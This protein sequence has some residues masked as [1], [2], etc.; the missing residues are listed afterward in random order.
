MTEQTHTHDDIIVFDV[1]TQHTFDEVGGIENRDKLGISYVGL[2]SYSQKK[3]FG[4]FEK[5]LPMLEKILLKT[6]PMLIG[7]NSIHFDVPVLQPYFTQ[8]NLSELPHLDMLKE[9][10]KVLGHRLKL[11]SIAQGTIFSQKSGDGLDAIR[12]YREG[13]FDALAKYCIDDVAITRDIYEFGEKQ[14]AI[15]YPAAGMRKAVKISWGKPPLIS[16]RIQEAYAQKKQLSID[17]FDLPKEG[18]AQRVTRTID[19][20]SMNGDSFDA[21]CHDLNNKHTLHISQVWDVKETGKSFAH[22]VSLF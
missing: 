10:E 14:G 17:Y 12:W 9:V 4:F 20:L 15:Y 2:Y 22:Q 21:F 6:R 3:M 11:D 7:F 16:E 8:I 5:D 1:E 19:I 13:N 18:S